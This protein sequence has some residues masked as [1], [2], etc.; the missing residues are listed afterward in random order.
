[1]A[2]ET[3]IPEQDPPGWE[4]PIPQK[5]SIP[6]A[7]T[8]ATVVPLVPGVIWAVRFYIHVAL[9]IESLL[10]GIERGAPGLV[11]LG[12]YT[13]GVSEPG[14]LLVAVVADDLFMG[15]GFRTADFVDFFFVIRQNSF[16]VFVVKNILYHTGV[17]I[18][19]PEF[20]DRL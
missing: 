3:E 19:N 11:R 15:F 4:Y 2:N 10:V 1:M 5:G 18:D 9:T 12:L 14:D 8:R 6:K 17:L 7:K 16:V 20:F 13:D